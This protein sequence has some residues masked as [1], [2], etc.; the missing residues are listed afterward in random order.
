MYLSAVCVYVCVWIYL[1]LC[2]LGGDYIAFT[3]VVKA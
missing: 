1:S 2:V 3:V